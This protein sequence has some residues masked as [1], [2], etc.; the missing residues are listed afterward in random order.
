M[1]ARHRVEY[2]PSCAF[3]DPRTHLAEPARQMRVGSGDL[4]FIETCLVN[5]FDDPAQQWDRIRPV[6]G[7]FGFGM[8]FINLEPR[9]GPRVEGQALSRWFNTEDG[10]VPSVVG[11]YEGCDD[12]A[13]DIQ[14][15]SFYHWD[16]IG[17]GHGGRSQGD[18][19]SRA[20]YGHV[21]APRHWRGLTKRGV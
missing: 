20:V 15:R 3:D 10:E 17:W 7:M 5:A 19:E 11:S 1:L 9:P 16:G 2:G 8:F 13:Q 21:T 18:A 4:N 14:R 12:V 6:V